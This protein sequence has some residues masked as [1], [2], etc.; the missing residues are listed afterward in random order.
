MAGT[1]GNGVLGVPRGILSGTFV[2]FLA[3]LGQKLS[4]LRMLLCPNGQ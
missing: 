2:S 3:G 4:V 1:L